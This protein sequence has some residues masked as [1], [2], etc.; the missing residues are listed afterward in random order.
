MSRYL[1]LRWRRAEVRVGT[2]RFA[3]PT[4]LLRDYLLGCAVFQSPRHLD[5]RLRG[6]DGDYVARG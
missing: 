2:L 6:G 4:T 3:H 5:P 1:R